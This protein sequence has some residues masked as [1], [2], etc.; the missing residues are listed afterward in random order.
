MAPVAICPNCDFEFTPP[1]DATTGEITDCPACGASI[2]LRGEFML[3]REPQVPQHML[4]AVAPEDNIEPAER[5]I[6]KWFRSADTVADVPPEPAHAAADGRL[7]EELS[8]APTLDM[9]VGPVESP[10]AEDADAELSPPEPLPEMGATWDDSERMERLLADLEK[11]PAD[12]YLPVPH[13]TPTHDDRA[14]TL[15]YSALDDVPAEEVRL[16]FGNRAPADDER[17]E[18]VAADVAVAPSVRPRRRRRSPLR[19]IVGSAVAAVIGLALGYLALLWILGPPGDVLNV[20]RYMPGAMLPSS[21]RDAPPPAARQ[22]AQTMAPPA[23]GRLTDMA[24]DNPSEPL[25]NPV[26]PTSG[27]ANLTAPGDSPERQASFEAPVAPP[28]ELRAQVGD[29]YADQPAAPIA[30]STLPREPLPIAANGMPAPLAA[31]PATQPM[32]RISG[33][34]SYSSEQFAAALQAAREALPGLL[35]G[36]LD[37]RAVQRNK[38]LSFSKLCD[39][40]EAATFIDPSQ[41][42]APEQSQAAVDAL[43]NETLA[44]PRIRNEIARIVPIWI[45]SAYRRHGGVFFAGSIVG[46]NDFGAMSECQIDLGAG[47]TLSILLP[48]DVANRLNRSQSV[49]VVGSLIDKPSERIAGYAGAAPQVVW[50]GS[51]TPLD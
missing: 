22:P 32:P 2:E 19:T 37:D 13:E 3:P 6:E 7:T 10:A 17:A 33:A 11:Q 46:R 31:E 15:E 20:A 28:S 30:T 16:D 34:P 21:L 14:E 8:P 29:R 39:L 44:D 4:G 50:V 23:A 12:D 24:D 35:A 47:T 5:R 18:V 45:G 25:P 42:S 43:F 49:A 26:A 48:P 40:A 51:L 27:L 41:S 1:A 38:G 36:E 9:V